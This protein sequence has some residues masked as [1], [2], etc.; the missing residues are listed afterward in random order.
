ME[1]PSQPVVKKKRGR[2]KKL[3]REISN[4]SSAAD[5]P[6]SLPSN[7]PGKRGRPRKVASQDLNEGP[8]EQ[9]SAPEDSVVD[10]PA[11]QVQNKSQKKKRH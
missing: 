9:I 2:P 3:V 5:P 11:D 4:D 6:E 10:L 8:S 1:E 7:I